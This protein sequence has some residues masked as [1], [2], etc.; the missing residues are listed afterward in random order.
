MNT[1]VFSSAFIDK[2]N[3][4]TNSDD[5]DETGEFVIAFNL[6]MNAELKTPVFI[7]KLNSMTNSAVS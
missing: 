3:A 5:G 4:M 7:D 6:S 1:G 2:L